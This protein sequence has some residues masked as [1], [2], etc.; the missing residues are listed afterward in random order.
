MSD[1]DD[2]YTK[3]KQAEYERIKTMEEA[4]VFLYGQLVY[5][6]ELNGLEELLGF[7]FN[8]NAYRKGA[9]SPRHLCGG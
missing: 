9:K 3:K 4:L 7:G 2:E 8:G 6:V 5:S 1:S